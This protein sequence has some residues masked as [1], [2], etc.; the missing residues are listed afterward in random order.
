MSTVLTRFEVAMPALNGDATHDGAI[1]TFLTNM[2]TICQLEV[3]DGGYYLLNGYPTGN[4]Q[5][6]YYGLLTS[7]QTSTALGY[8]NTLNA[9]LGFNVPCI[10]F[11]VTQ[12]P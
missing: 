9:A 10:S 8:L 5:V 11:Q 3:Y 6:F 7:T 4:Y 12:Q 2:N 1:N